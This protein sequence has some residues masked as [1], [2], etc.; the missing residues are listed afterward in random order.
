MKSNFL[1]SML[2]FIRPLYNEK[3]RP[4]TPFRPN[5]IRG[6]QLKG[7]DRLFDLT[8][9][10]DDYKL[11]HISSIERAVLPSD[12][13]LIL[14]AG[15]GVS[16]LALANQ[17]RQITLVEGSETQMRITEQNLDANHVD[18]VNLLLGVA[19]QNIGVY[20]SEDSRVI[21]LHQFETVRVVAMDIEGAEMSVIPQ[22]PE[23]VE[24]V[25]IESHAQ[26][27]SPKKSVME[28]LENHGFV[29]EQ[30]IDITPGNAQISA[31]R[32]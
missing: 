4:K 8:K 18:N 32:V 25:I 14:G 11:E 7:P 12:H 24:K 30:A 29:I 20:N 27:G 17:V 10:G 21:D 16:A 19:G 22:L 15:V 1:A 2:D 5:N 3:I 23:S 13:L 6:F 28:S 9:P 26:F 31:S